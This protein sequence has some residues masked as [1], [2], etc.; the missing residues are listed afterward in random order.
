MSYSTP[1]HFQLCVTCQ[2]QHTW[3]SSQCLACHIQER[4]IAP[5]YL[6][7]VLKYEEPQMPF[8]FHTFQKFIYENAAC[9]LV[10]SIDLKELSNKAREQVQK[11]IQVVKRS[12]VYLETELGSGSGQFVKN[13]KLISVDEKLAAYQH[14]YLHDMQFGKCAYCMEALSAEDAIFDQVIPLALKHCGVVSPGPRLAYRQVLYES[15]LGA[16]VCWRCNRV[17]QSWEVAATNIW[18]AVRG[19]LRRF[20][21]AHPL[22]RTNPLR[23]VRY[24]HNP[25][26]KKRTRHW[27][28]DRLD[29]LGKYFPLC[30][31][32]TF[33]GLRGRQDVYQVYYDKQ[34]QYLTFD[35][36]IRTDAGLR[37]GELC[38]VYGTPKTERRPNPPVESTEDNETD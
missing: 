3:P 20:A 36:D 17:K 31:L 21:P 15:G 30:A 26:D 12:Q 28:R 1:V 33:V 34:C 27:G 25:G 7:L 22:V 37:I 19:G 18:R 4:G 38:K 6:A 35:A 32:G 14:V 10:D 13:A 24:V 9:L 11:R 5:P 2:S 8:R 29:Y 16:L 23:T